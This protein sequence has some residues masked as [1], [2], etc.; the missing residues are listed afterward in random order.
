M[1]GLFFQESIP[2]LSVD[3]DLGYYLCHN[4]TPKMSIRQPSPCKLDC[5]DQFQVSTVF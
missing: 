5:R 4:F 3:Q 1:A 2:N